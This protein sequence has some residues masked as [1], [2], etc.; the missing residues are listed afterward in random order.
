M[1]PIQLEA[2]RTVADI[3]STLA[4][5]VG[6]PLLGAWAARKH[7]IQ[8]RW[9]PLIEA[10][11]AAGF[12]AGRCAGTIDSPAFRDAAAA[13]IV[14]YVK[15]QAPDVIAAKGMSDSDIGDAGLAR[16]S[17]LTYGAVG[18]SGTAVVPAPAN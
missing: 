12:N 1:T 11:A 4:I 16:V 15:R 2:V 10:A 5:T 14:S 8:Q 17:R 9:V 6:I 18:P 13:E 7:L 3:A